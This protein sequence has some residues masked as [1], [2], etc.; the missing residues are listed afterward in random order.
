MQRYELKQETD[1]TWCVIDNLS[2][3]PVTAGGRLLKELSIQ[4]ARQ[5]V[6]QLNAGIL[7]D[8]ANLGRGRRP[9]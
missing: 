6:F 7:L 5:A 1:K 8:S 3:L 2:G 9:E 4:E